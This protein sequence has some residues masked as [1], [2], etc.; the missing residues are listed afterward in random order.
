M[1][2][3]KGYDVIIL[4]GQSNADGFG[5][6]QT[7]QKYDER[8]ELLLDEQLLA[9]YG[10]LDIDYDNFHKDLYPAKI[11]KRQ[12]YDR[13]EDGTYRGCFAYSFAK[14]YLK[15]GLLKDGRKLLVVKTAVGGTGFY[16]K[17]W[18]VGNTLHNRM[19]QMV[20]YAMNLD[21]DNKIVAML[22]HQGESDTDIF[23][24]IPTSERYDFYYTR[25]F[26]TFNA[27]REKYGLPNLPI[28]CGQTTNEF[29]NL[30]KENAETVLNATVDV[31]KKLDNTAFVRSDGLKTNNEEL[32]N[33]DFY[34]F[35]YNSL[36]EFGKRYFKAFQEIIK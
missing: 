25:L 17:Q 1:E 15:N 23:M 28:V 33:G 26:E 24:D 12:A 13:Q 22:W 27:V 6:S 3:F 29:F 31:C 10:K 20:D 34:H 9:I 16:R 14:E 11:I 19:I 30:N 8:I 2:N 18:G 35:S 32:G 7:N 36:I 21:G 4:A 5:I